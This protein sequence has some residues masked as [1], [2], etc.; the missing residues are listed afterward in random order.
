MDVNILLLGC[1]FVVCRWGQ[2]FILDSLAQYTPK[3][4][5]EAQRYCTLYLIRKHSARM[6]DSLLGCPQLDRGIEVHVANIKANDVGLVP[7][8]LGGL[9]HG[10]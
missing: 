8:C 6:E 2:I 3:D 1:C 5:R 10:V 7:K 9:L 4:D